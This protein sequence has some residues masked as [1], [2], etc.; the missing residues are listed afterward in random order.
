L[1]E[2]QEA[3]VKNLPSDVAFPLFNARQA[4]EA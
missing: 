2:R 4:L 1:V 3:Y